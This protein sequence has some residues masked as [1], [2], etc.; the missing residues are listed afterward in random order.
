[1]A[2]TGEQN[3]RRGWGHALYRSGDLPP[4][5]I[6][7][8][9]VG[10]HDIDAFPTGQGRGKGVHPLVAAARGDDRVAVRPKGIAQ[11]LEQEWVV[12]HEQ[13]AQLRAGSG[14]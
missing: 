11:R 3:H 4:I 6:R 9:Q 12:I 5:D 7:H 10:D 13:D 1:M 2:P 8:A 14:T